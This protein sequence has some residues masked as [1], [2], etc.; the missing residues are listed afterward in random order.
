MA[1]DK[2]LESGGARTPELCFQILGACAPKND[3]DQHKNMPQKW[4]RFKKS[5]NLR[6]MEHKQEDLTL[7]S[8]AKKKK[9]VEFF[10]F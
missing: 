1:K 3:L 10:F 7:D 5:E 9:V 6:Q 4:K 2:M 8:I